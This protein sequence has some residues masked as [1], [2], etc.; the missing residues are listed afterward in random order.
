M[1]ETFCSCDFYVTLISKDNFDSTLKMCKC[2]TGRV[3]LRNLW[4]EM[5]FQGVAARNCAHLP[6]SFVFLPPRQLRLLVFLALAFGH[7]SW[8]KLWKRV[9]SIVF[10]KLLGTFFPPFKIQKYVWGLWRCLTC[11]AALSSDHPE[12]FENLP[13]CPVPGLR[14]DRSS[15]L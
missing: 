12:P 7:L 9:C 10:K 4:A 3:S 8:E 1:L 13:G 11:V 15:L 6:I 14:G 5:V 2:Q